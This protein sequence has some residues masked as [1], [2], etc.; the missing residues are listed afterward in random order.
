MARITYQ[1]EK[2]VEEEDL[3]LSLLDISLKHG[4]PHLHVC[5]RTSRCSTC[6]VE[7]LAHPENVAPRNETE[8]KFARQQNLG[9]NVR[10]AC[11]TYLTGPVTI[12]RRIQEQISVHDSIMDSVQFAGSEQNLAI[13]FA[14]IRDFTGLSERML[15][16]DLFHAMNRYYQHM[17]EIVLKHHGFLHQYYGDGMMVLFGFYARESRQ[18]C[19]DAVSAGLEMLTALEA[20]NQ[21]M[22][23]QFNEKLK[24]GVGIHYGG[25]LAGK[26]GHAKYRHLTVLGDVVNMTQRIEGATKKATYPML[27]S[28]KVYWELGPSVLKV[29]PFMAKLKGKVGEHRLYEVERFATGFDKF[30]SVC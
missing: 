28:D 18:I 12:R 30:N 3:C 9:E 26:I 6:Q 7:I 8:A 29:H 15:P 22:E 23:T 17:G 27:I 2:T 10:L 11:Q 21:F 4:I 19:L 13:L 14:D 5:G 20:F 16:Y 24:I 1:D 25:I